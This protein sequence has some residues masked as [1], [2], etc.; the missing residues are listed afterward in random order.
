M[1]KIIGIIIRKNLDKSPLLITI[2][3]F[4]HLKYNKKTKCYNIHMIHDEQNICS[5]LD[6]IFVIL[7]HKY[8]KHKQLIFKKFLITFK[9]SE[10]K[11]LYKEKKNKGQ[12]KN[13]TELKKITKYIFNEKN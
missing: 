5:L 12:L 6:N 9:L 2:N 4:K 3:F 8:S 11:K 13:I 10:K 1:H 7:T